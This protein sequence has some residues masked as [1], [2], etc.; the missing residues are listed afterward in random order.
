M[1]K[2]NF[3]KQITAL[4]VAIFTDQYAFSGN[5]VAITDDSALIVVDVQ[6]CFLDGG[7]LPVPDG[8]SIIPKINKIAL[9]F[10]NIVITQ[11]WHPRNH[12]SF[13]STHAGAKPFNA[14]TTSY[15][16]QVLWPDHCIQGTKDANLDADLNLPTAQLIIR[17]GFNPDVDSYSAFREADRRTLTGLY[18]YLRERNI[19]TVFV[20]GLATDF[21]VSSTAIDAVDLGLKSYVIEDACRG[22][23]INGSLAKAIYAMQNAGVSIIKSSELAEN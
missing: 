20:V 8:K 1:N 7:T 16:Q 6:N 21:C 9:D 15:G 10:K 19:N 5:R 18:A 3:I 11:D 22:I 13:A 23:N 2:R 4:G 12:S 14:I 17:K